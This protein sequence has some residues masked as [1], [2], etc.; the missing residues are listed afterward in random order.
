MNNVWAHTQ[1]QSSRMHVCNKASYTL[2][3]N[4]RPNTHTLQYCM[5][6]HKSITH[7]HM[8]TH[9]YNSCFLWLA[10]ITTQASILC[11]KCTRHV[12]LT[13]LCHQWDVYRPVWVTE[14]KREGDMFYYVNVREIWS[15]KIVRSYYF[16]IL[17]TVCF[18]KNC[19][20]RNWWDLGTYPHH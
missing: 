11:P 13:E 7:I 2:I 6:G 10:G 18:L 19:T 9:T 1:I 3:H 4:I 20:Q 5:C 15:W 8:D 12:L 17:A 14:R 16:L